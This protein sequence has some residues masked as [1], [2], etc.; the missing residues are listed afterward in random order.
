M[1]DIFIHDT[2]VIDKGAR[3]GT[4]SKVW[5]FSHISAGAEIGKF[6]NI[7][8]NVFIGN[9]CK[10]G[11]HCKIQNNV[12]IYDNIYLGDYVFCGPS[13]V[14]TNVYN[15]R[16]FIE[17]KSEYRDTHISLG[18][19]LGA[20]STIVCGITIGEYA[21]I[22]AGSVVNRDIKPYAL[23][24]GVPGRQIGWMSRYGNKLDLPLDGNGKATCS[25]TSD[26]YILSNGLLRIE[27]NA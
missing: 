10:V 24:A 11:D 19:T 1:K 15:P 2:S 4:G 25:F 9:K 12:S 18:V 6:V 21:F 13:V 27:E 7:G 5:H 26:K 3:I 8:Q 17:R 22:A 20:N 16:A 23:I 14:F